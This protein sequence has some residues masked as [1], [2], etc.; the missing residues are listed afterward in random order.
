MPEKF[1][2]LSVRESTPEFGNYDVQIAGNVAGRLY[3]VP[4]GE[5]MVGSG[6]VSE[7]FI[8]KDGAIQSG[9]IDAFGQWSLSESG[10]LEL[11]KVYTGQVEVFVQVFDVDGSIVTVEETV[12]VE[13]TATVATVVAVEEMLA[14]EV[15]VLGVAVTEA[16]DYETI[17]RS[18]FVQEPLPSAR[19]RSAQIE[20]ERVAAELAVIRQL[21]ELD[22]EQL[23]KMAQNDSG[24]WW[25]VVEADRVLVFDTEDGHTVLASTWDGEVLSPL[26][27]DDARVSSRNLAMLS[28]AIG[29]VD[30]GPQEVPPEEI[31]A[32]GSSQDR[33]SKVAGSKG[34]ELEP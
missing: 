15:G 2:L 17:R 9:Y 18:S 14:R 26:S 20:A 8:T 33:L 6:I 25:L 24:D 30:A 32:L 31:A 1:E 16:A 29:G 12:A 13:E 27:I 23:K 11:G 4:V 10:S 19:S 22:R 5:A 3:V 21:I 7:W 34:V 28:A